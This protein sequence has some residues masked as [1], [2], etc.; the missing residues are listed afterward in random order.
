MTEKEINK[1]DRAKEAILFV[2]YMNHPNPMKKEDIEAKILV[3]G[4]LK[5]SDKEFELYKRKFELT[6]LN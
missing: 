4:L 3:D 5:M 1:L 2:L 6:K